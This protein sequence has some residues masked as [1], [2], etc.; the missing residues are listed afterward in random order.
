MNSEQVNYVYMSKMS[1]MLRLVPTM[2]PANPIHPSKKFR[3]S[4]HVLVQPDVVYQWA[5]L[6]K[7]AGNTMPNMDNVRAP[8]NEMKMSR[9]GITI[10]SKTKRIII[11][12]LINS[13]V[14]LKTI[15][16]IHE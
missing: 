12:I 6:S 7:N 15:V 9:F 4:I 5:Q 1:F 8:I 2:N 11:I 10:A 14:K 13:S 3:N 16:E